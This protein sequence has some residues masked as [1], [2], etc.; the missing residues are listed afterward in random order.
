MLRDAHNWP[1]FVATSSFCTEVWMCVCSCLRST[2]SQANASLWQ[3]NQPQKAVLTYLLLQDHTTRCTQMA[4]ICRHQ[5]SL[6]WGLDVCAQLF[7]KH[8]QPNEGRALAARS[9]AKNCVERSDAA[10]LQQDD[11]TRCTQMTAICRHQQTLHWG[12]DAVSYTH[13]TLPT[14]A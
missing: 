10:G 14:K 11:T 3:H 8:M 6:H 13:L 7:E 4:A 1:P 12:L 5:Q 9:A 2:S